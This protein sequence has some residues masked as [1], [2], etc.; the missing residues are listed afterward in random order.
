MIETFPTAETAW[1]WTC[2]VLRARAAGRAGPPGPC[3]TEDVLRG[4]DRLYRNRRLELLHVRV[5]RR[6]GW[7]GHPPGARPQDGFDRVLW[8]E[9]LGRLT[10]VWQDAGVIRSPT[11]RSTL[12]TDAAP[13]PL[14]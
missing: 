9:A 1:F 8:T 3:R 11:A 5:L 10:W 14:G 2:A 6:W 12:P 7:R 13:R 4:L